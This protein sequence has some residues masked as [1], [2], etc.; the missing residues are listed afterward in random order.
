MERQEHALG[1]HAP[2]QARPGQ[3]FESACTAPVEG[4]VPSCDIMAWAARP[5]SGEDRACWRKHK[6]AIQ[7]GAHLGHAYPHNLHQRVSAYVEQ[8]KGMR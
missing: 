8:I 3:E 2:G 1:A 5:R 4:M 6:V 7:V